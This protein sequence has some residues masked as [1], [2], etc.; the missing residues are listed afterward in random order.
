MSAVSRRRCRRLRLMHGKMKRDPLTEDIFAQKVI[1]VRLLY[2]G[3]EDV[4]CRGI[5]PLR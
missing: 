4:L 5:L 2:R 3:I 1:I